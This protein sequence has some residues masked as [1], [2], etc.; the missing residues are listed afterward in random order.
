MLHFLRSCIK[1][2]CFDTADGEQD[3]DYERFFTEQHH[4]KARYSGW[5]V[6]VCPSVCLSHS[7]IVRKRQFFSRPGSSIILDF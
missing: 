3:F 1:M 2:Y 5:L 7:C 6:S 4:A